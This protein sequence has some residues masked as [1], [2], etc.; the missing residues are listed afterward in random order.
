MPPGTQT[1]GGTAEVLRLPC[2]PMSDRCESCG[3]DGPDLATVQRVFVLFDEQHQP[4]GHRLADEFETW[5]A[6]C[7]TTYPHEPVAAS[8]DE[9]PQA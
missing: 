2:P 3:D 7:R 8:D 5:C 9:A 4:V 1:P 6:V